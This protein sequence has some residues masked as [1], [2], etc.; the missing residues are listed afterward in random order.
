MRT[1]SDLRG[2]SPLGLTYAYGDVMDEN[3]LIAAAD[4]CD[5]IIHT[6]AVYQY[7]ARDPDEI[8]QPALVGTRNIFSA[9]RAVGAKR[10]V[11]T[12]SVWAMGT[13][14]DPN[15]RLTAKDWNEHS[16]NPYAVAK[17]KSEQ[18]AWRLAEAKDIP[19]IAICP[20]GVFGPYDYRPTPTMEALRDLVNGALFTFDTGVGYVDVR[21]V[22]EIHA[23]AVTEG[24]PG[25]RYGVSGENLQLRD[26]GALIGRLTGFTPPHLP[27]GRTTFGV[28]ASLAEFA[29]RVTR[30]KPLLTSA[31][32]HDINKRY[33]FID[34]EETW[35]DFD[36]RP[37]TSKEMVSDAVR[38]LH[39]IGEV[40]PKRAGQLAEQSQLNLEWNLA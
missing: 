15:V 19:M 23:R 38:W 31:L 36:Y 14:D 11:Y 33:L 20:N 26:L 29:A 17:T 13:S 9:A 12:S 5:V 16:E 28:L 39:H 4:G 34:C 7:W 1:R 8:M 24:E 32:I 21:D 37:R 6:A 35:R 3:S 18:A 10:V 40:R 25:K 2:L 30:L 27:L 22:A